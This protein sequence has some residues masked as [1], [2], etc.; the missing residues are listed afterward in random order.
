[1]DSEMEDGSE[2]DRS[3]E[4]D[5]IT[6]VEVEETPRKAGE[7]QDGASKEKEV[8]QKTKHAHIFLENC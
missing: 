8:S 7:K 6:D 3:T 4:V 5:D 1:M 2:Q